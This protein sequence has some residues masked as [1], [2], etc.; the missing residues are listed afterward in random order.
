MYKLVILD[1]Q[2]LSRSESAFGQTSLFCVAVKR[3]ENGNLP[4]AVR[5]GYILFEALI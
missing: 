2:C 3:V 4:V 5:V 1:G